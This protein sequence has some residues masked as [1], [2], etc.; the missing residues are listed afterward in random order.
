[1]DTI[2]KLNDIKSMDSKTTLLQFVLVQV[3]SEINGPFFT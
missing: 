3:E 1:M 2:E